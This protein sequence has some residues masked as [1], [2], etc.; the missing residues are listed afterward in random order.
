MKD[1]KI[2]PAE[3]GEVQALQDLN[4]KI[5]VDNPKYDPDLRLDWA[6]SEDGGKKYFTDLL[7]SSDSICLIAEADNK[8]IGYIA[9]SPKEINYR[10]S[11]YVEIENLGVVPEYR[12][13]GIGNK[14]MEKCLQLAKGKGFNKVYVNTYS[15]NTKAVDFY[16]RNGFAEIDISLEKEI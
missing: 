6:Q 12:S 10:N 7:N 1:I 8:M 11:K 3:N 16:R 4:D 2:R 5:F 14:L 15:Q 13:L 9:A